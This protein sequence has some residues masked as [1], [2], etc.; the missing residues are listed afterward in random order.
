MT[1]IILVELLSSFNI[2]NNQN[3]K[4]ISCL[5]TNDNNVEHNYKPKEKQGKCLGR[6]MKFY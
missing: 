2:I 3:F 5:R 4:G 1:A 6:K